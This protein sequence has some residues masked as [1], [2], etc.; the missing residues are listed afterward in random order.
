MTHVFYFYKGIIG[1]V[2]KAKS[3]PSIPSFYK[4][5]H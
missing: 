1:L 2:L 4:S 5:T 3:S